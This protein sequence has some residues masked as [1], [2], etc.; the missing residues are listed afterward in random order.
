M[1]KKRQAIKLDGKG[2]RLVTPSERN[3]RLAGLVA[4]AA[5]ALP[6]TASAGSIRR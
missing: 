3:L 2:A 4:V 5:L 1:D 6:T